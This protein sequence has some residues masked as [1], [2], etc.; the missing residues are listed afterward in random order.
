[1]WI[2]AGG[3]IVRATL[4]VPER[5]M[6]N[7]SRTLDETQQNCRS[8]F[9]SDISLVSHIQRPGTHLLHSS[10]SVGSKPR[11]NIAP[12]AQAH[13]MSTSSTHSHLTPSPS[14]PANQ[15]MCKTIKSAHDTFRS[16]CKTRTLFCCWSSSA[17]KKKS[18]QWLRRFKTINKQTLICS[19]FTHIYLYC[20]PRM[21][22]TLMSKG[23]IIIYTT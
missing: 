13:P 12:I 23:T 20:I 7:G 1:M 14:T 17:Q 11:V 9:R 10:L 6:L 16:R 5:K 2:H 8:P 18:K 22:L 4:K 21:G 15:T 19:Y 3:C